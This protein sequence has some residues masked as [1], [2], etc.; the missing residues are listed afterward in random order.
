[1]NFSTTISY[2]TITSIACVFQTEINEDTRKPKCI[3][4]WI[5]DDLLLD[6]PAEIGGYLPGHLIEEKIMHQETDS[7][8]ELKPLL[9]AGLVP[10]IDTIRK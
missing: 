3:K 4:A 6:V 5:F 8:L 7:Q 2:V 10:T 1:M 9:L